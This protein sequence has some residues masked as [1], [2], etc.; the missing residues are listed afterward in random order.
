V[1]ARR[2]REVVDCTCARMRN[3]SENRGQQISK[4]VDRLAFGI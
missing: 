2:F 4:P 1:T 3:A